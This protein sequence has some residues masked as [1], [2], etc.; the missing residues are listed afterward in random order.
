MNEA[1]NDG[2]YNEIANLVVKT[3]PEEWNEV[4]L[5]GDVVDGTQIAYFY[6][7]PEG[8]KTP[9]YSHIFQNY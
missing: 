2:I 9:V 4:F 3:I 7:Y 6:Y 8:K 1:K 5:Y